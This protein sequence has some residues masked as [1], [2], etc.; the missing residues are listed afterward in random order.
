MIAAVLKL[1]GN[2]SK[3]M[4]L[5]KSFVKKGVK[6]TLDNLINLAEIP[7]FCLEYK[8]ISS[9]L[10]ASETKKCETKSRKL[11]IKFRKLQLVRKKKMC[12]VSVTL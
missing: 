11:Q 10:R 7:S 4:H 2:D 3:E 1:S 12:K 5:L 8:V 9:F 6:T